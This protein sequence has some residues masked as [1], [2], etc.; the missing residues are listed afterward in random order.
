MD[1]D[2]HSAEAMGMDGCIDFDHE[3]NKGLESIWCT[4]CPLTKLYRKKY[5]FISKADFWVISSNAVIRQLS[6]NQ[7]LDLV[8]TFL[9]GRQDTE[10]CEDSGDR[11]P[12]GTSTCQDVEATMLEAMG[13]EWRDAV[14]LLGAHTIGKGHAAFSGHDG[15]QFLSFNTFVS[16]CDPN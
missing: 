16:T 10:S 5:S 4:S 8:N 1:Y 9:W 14:A 13:L 2:Q 7:S 15:M 11:I 3:V 6:K 12:R